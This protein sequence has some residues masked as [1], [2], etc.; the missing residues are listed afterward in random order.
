MWKLQGDFQTNVPEGNT[1]QE[2]LPAWD[3]RTEDENLG[4]I[5]DKQEPPCQPQPEVQ[6]TELE[7][8]SG[9]DSEHLNC[10]SEII[11]K[12]TVESTTIADTTSSTTSASAAG[13]ASGDRC[14]RAVIISSDSS[15]TQ[16]PSISAGRSSSSDRS[17]EEQD[18]STDSSVPV[19]M[20]VKQGIPTTFS[21]TTLTN[22]HG[23]DLGG[24]NGWGIPKGLGLR[25]KIKL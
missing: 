19:S 14:S 24:F 25:Y 18:M 9:P 22:S 1:V 7:P 11:P 16:V 23:C 20:E 12:T 17:K 5:V 6:V 4:V 3:V 8:E 13:K 15:S 21:S 2:I 10:T